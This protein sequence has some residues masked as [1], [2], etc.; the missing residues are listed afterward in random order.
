MKTHH[1]CWSEV[2][3]KAVSFCLSSLVALMLS[4]VPGSTA[5]AV[6]LE[7]YPQLIELADRLAQEQHLDRTQLL[8]WFEQAQIKEKI[9]KAMNRPAERLSW[10]RYRGLFVNEGSVGNGIKFTKQ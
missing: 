3:S 10:H 6:S 1:M 9:I 7:K 8:E 2:V 4:L 5:R